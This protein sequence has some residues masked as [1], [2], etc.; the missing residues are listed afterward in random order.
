MAEK[1]G[2]PHFMLKEIY[3]QPWAVRETVLGR[4]SL[5]SGRV[6][7]EEMQIDAGDAHGDRTRRHRRVRDVVA[8]GPGRQVPDRGTRARAGRGGLRIGVPLPAAASA[9]GRGR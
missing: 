7:L 5:E 9:R 4:T 8:R 3:E 1:A 2:Y 6:F